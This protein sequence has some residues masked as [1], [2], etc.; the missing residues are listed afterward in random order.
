MGLIWKS[1]FSEIYK[2]HVLSSSAQNY[3][4]IYHILLLHSTHYYV[5]TL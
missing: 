5:A 4:R 2:F 1:N 3:T